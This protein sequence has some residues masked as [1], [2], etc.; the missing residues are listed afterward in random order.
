M[1]EILYYNQRKSPFWSL[2]G[3]YQNQSEI[4]QSEIKFEI[5]NCY[6]LFFLLYYPIPSAIVDKY[7]NKYMKQNIGLL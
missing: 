7:T 3:V 2:N 4:I 1:I 5:L 6:N